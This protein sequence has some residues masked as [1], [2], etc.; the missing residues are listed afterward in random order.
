MA[1]ANLSVD[2]AITEA[3]LSAQAQDSNTRCIKVAIMDERL[4]L[5]SIGTRTGSTESDFANVL[6]ASVTDNEAALVLYSLTET[7]NGKSNNSWLL[8]LWVPDLCRVRDKMLYSSSKEDLKRSLGQGYFTHEYSSNTRSD[9]TWSEFQEAKKKERSADLLT[10]TERSV[11]EERL[12]SHAESTA[13]KSTAMN[14]LPFN[15]DPELKARLVDF[16]AG[17]INWITMTVSD[18]TVRLVDAKIVGELASGSLQSHVS[19]T[20]SQFILTRMS[21]GPSGSTETMSFFVFSC[22]ESVPIRSKMVM[23]SAKA[24]VLAIVAE[25]GLTF[26]KNIEILDSA[27]IDDMIKIE[28]EPE[29]L[30]GVSGSASASLA[31][32]KPLRPGQRSRTSKPVAKFAADDE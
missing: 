10:E 21:K 23:S 30:G 9:L 26:V 19:S 18:E 15:V 11:F 1:R 3:F 22:P 31:H 25:A 4:V 12:A 6:A 24:T 16:K 20:E 2:S 8:L 28:L 7:G 32:T 13:T 5:Q 14:V 17:G 29:T 27:D